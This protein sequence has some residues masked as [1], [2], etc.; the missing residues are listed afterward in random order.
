MYSMATNSE[1][2]ILSFPP[3]TN[4]Q[5]CN[6]FEIINTCTV[7]VSTCCSGC[8]SVEYTMH[9]YFNLL[10]SQLLIH[11][12]E[13]FIISCSH[14]TSLHLQLIRVAFDLVK[15]V[16]SYLLYSKYYTVLLIKSMQL[17]LSWLGISLFACST[18][19]YTEF[20][21]PKKTFPKLREMHLNACND[22]NYKLFKSPTI[23]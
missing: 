15:E 19:H 6:I 11:N 16:W 3:V 2:G 5:Y 23:Q 8:N 13:I 21:C 10:Y 4:I 1:S 20:I 17:M 22:T 9:Y 14:P 18:L 7:H 12:H